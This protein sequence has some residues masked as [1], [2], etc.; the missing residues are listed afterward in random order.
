MWI[1]ALLL[2]TLLITIPVLFNSF[3]SESDPSSPGLT[4]LVF[5]F[6]LF[7]GITAY[8]L[9][10]YYFQPKPEQMVSF[11]LAFTMLVILP[12]CINTTAVS[13]VSLR[14]LR[15]SVASA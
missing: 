8:C 6:S 12:V 2:L 9:A 10:L 3:S 11:L 13:M 7:V 4:G 14:G 1:Q 15:E 5:G